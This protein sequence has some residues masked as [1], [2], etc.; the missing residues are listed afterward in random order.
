MNQSAIALLLALGAGACA[1]AA[2]RPGPPPQRIVVNERELTERLDSAKARIDAAGLRG[3]LAGVM[4]RLTPGAT[5]VID[6]R[7]T[8]RGRD[9]IARWLNDRGAA[10]AAAKVV[11]RDAK[12]FACRD[13]ALELQGTLL[14]RL[15]GRDDVQPVNA[16]YFAKWRDDG[17]Q[18]WRIDWL[19]ASR[20][21]DRAPDL[22][23]LCP[24]FRGDE[25]DA[26]RVF[27]GLSAGPPV[28]QSVGDDISGTMSGRG[29]RPGAAVY[30]TSEYETRS[31]SAVDESIV[32][33]RVVVWRQ[34]WVQALAQ[35]GRVSW[36]RYGA[37]G[38][39]Q[40]LVRADT[41]WSGAMA[42]W[43]WGRI[44][45]GAGLVAYDAA[46]STLEERPLPLPGSARVL[47]QSARQPTG[48]IAEVAYV[49]P[50]PST[51]W[52]FAEFRV[53]H[54]AGSVDAPGSGIYAPSS[55][56][57]GGTRFQVHVGFAVY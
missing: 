23:R 31:P 44:R 27:V 29:Y 15:G 45:A 40:V 35:P 6:G 43:Q 28:G 53:Q 30:L 21:V 19:E 54:R 8:L 38:T 24:G 13:G 4:D 1:P 16:V 25:F 2:F 33:L 52:L 26:R 37:S 48:F 9:A 5:V 7:D 41:R 50:V 47:N 32:S 11:L 51:N 12:L 3:D 46:T 14:T 34:L 17:P 42:G 39:S 55:V 18:G 49:L 10:T 20:A 22:G 36:A 56:A 57:L